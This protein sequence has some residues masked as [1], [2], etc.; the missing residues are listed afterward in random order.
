MTA[1]KRRSRRVGHKRFDVRTDAVDAV[2]EALGYIG[3][4]TPKSLTN[5][6]RPHCTGDNKI[7]YKITLQ[8]VHWNHKLSLIFHGL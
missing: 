6:W 8:T 2:P 4:Y 5:Y 7:R 1:G 3:V